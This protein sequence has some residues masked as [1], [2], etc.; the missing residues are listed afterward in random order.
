MKSKVLYAQRL[1]QTS[2]EDRIATETNERGDG[3]ETVE[4][5]LDSLGLHVV[6]LG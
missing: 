4:K 6:Y 5:C 1:T 2:V 3:I